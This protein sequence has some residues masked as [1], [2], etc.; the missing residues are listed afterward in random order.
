MPD[1]NAL[2]LEILRQDNALAMSVF[3]HGEL[4]STLRHYSKLPFLFPEAN[5]LCQEILDVLNKAGKE[6]RQENELADHLK[7]AG[8]LLWDHLLTKPVKEKLK[9]TQVLD[10]ILSIDEELVNIP[11]ELLYTG[12]DFLCLKFNLGRV[13]RT[14]EQ[15]N[16]P[17]YRSLSGNPKMLILVNPTAD[18]KS[19]YSEGVFIKNQFVHRRKEIS[20]DFKS[21]NIDTIYVK[22]NLRDY[23]IVHFAGHC[24]YDADRPKNSGWVLSDKVFTV[25][26]ICVMGQTLSLPTLVFSNA[27][28]S[29]K[30]QDSL[31]NKDCQQRTYSLASA[32]LFSGVRHYIGTI[33]KIEDPISLTF[34]K[35]FYSRLISG[36][37]VG[38]S[39]RLSRLK[40]VKE[41]GIAAISW[42]S[43][44]LYGDPKF[45]LFRIKTRSKV[46][47][48]KRA[49]KKWLFKFATLIFLISVLGF[50]YLWLPTMNPNTYVLFLKS[51]NLFTN[52]DNEKAVLL[53]KG[54]IDKEPLFLAA[55]PLLGDAY[56]RM[57]KKEEALKYYFD[58]AI[59]SQKR[60]DKKNLTEA[61]IRIGWFYNL[62]GDYPKALDF[63]RKTIDLSRENKY[64]LYEAMALRKLAVWYID[65][66]DY[67]KAL[68]LLTKSSE[69]NRERK[70]IYE[71]KYNLACDYFDIGLVFANKD[72][73]VAAKEFYN[74]SRILFESLKAKDELSDYYFN[75]GEIYLLE[76]QYQK[77]LENYMKG[78]KIDQ[79]QV[80][81]PNL[82]SDYNMIGELY[83]AM[84]N[85]TEAEKFFN[86]ALLISREISVSIE[87]AEAYYNLGSLYKKRNQKNK[88]KEYFRQAQEIYYSI[89]PS[90]YQEV[91]NELMAF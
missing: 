46:T 64:K 34:A 69:I 59:Y 51:R 83:L 50:L 12:E 13:V 26:D 24:Q 68:E 73:L 32:F 75:L 54:I 52:G 65:K 23:D 90:R 84:D 15:S 67:D 11:W 35:E 60:N 66:K 70:N 10:L 36:H 48:S 81:K 47:K 25:N 87:L 55:Y 57:G 40:L 49:Y 62:Q 6:V 37:S 31:L 30:S 79:A 33:R 41:H 8:Q 63:Y 80:N 28:H 89:D 85:L 61:Y 20:I 45:T 78:L 1:T 44:I 7:K 21:T 2:V 58:Y 77:A 72:D 16:L 19:A 43:Y 39:M 86:Q 71:Y 74:K 76:K 91:K 5:N 22:K 4:A 53:S 42:A 18:L 27:C 82:A 9:A 17:Q 88:S 29:A 38:E 56:Q 3:D 14:R